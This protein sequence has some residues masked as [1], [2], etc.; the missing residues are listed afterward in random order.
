MRLIE[1]SFLLH[2]NAL[3]DRVGNVNANSKNGEGR[4]WTEAQ[5][6]ARDYLLKEC[7]PR[8]PMYVYYC[9]PFTP[10]VRNQATDERYLSFSRNSPKRLPWIRW[11]L[12]SLY[13]SQVVIRSFPSSIGL[14]RCELIL[15]VES[16][17]TLPLQRLWMCSTQLLQKYWVFLF[18]PLASSDVSSLVKLSPSAV[19]DM[20]RGIHPR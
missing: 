4:Y 5:E 2:R 7:L 14:S 1:E 8:D 19:F 12:S 11:S 17:S 6:Q 9:Q 20:I 13:S 18:C 10:Q 15:S 3:Q 16:N